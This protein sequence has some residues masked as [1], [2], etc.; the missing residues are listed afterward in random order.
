M[1]KDPVITI[2]CQL[3]GIQVSPKSYI[4]GCY[5][6]SSMHKTTI[7]TKTNKQTNKKQ[8]NN[9]KKIK[10]Q[11][12]CCCMLLV[13]LLPCSL[14]E[15][16]ACTITHLNEMDIKVIVLIMQILLL[17]SLSECTLCTL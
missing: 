2:D 4:Q 13:A 5:A 3:S 9:K 12:I 11:E 6:A 16:H 17:G 14:A 7:T 1:T 10:P 15:L 8:N